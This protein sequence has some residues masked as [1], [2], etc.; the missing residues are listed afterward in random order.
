MQISTS[1]EL[2]ASLHF[3]PVA[4][5]FVEQSSRSL[6][7]AGQE[8]LALT[9]AA[10]ELFTRFSR[11]IQ[12]DQAVTIEC[13]AGAYYVRADFLFPVQ[14][15][16]LRAFNLTS[17][18]SLQD[19]AGLDE[20]GLF[21]ASRSVDQFQVLREPDRRVRLILIKERSYP[22]AG[23]PPALHPE[24][25]PSYT[26]RAPEAEELRLLAA[27][28][29][30]RY[31]AKDYP[32]FFRYPGK[33]ADMVSGGE[34]QAAV[35]LGPSGGMGG[36]LLWRWLT[37]QTAEF[38]GPYVFP[39]QPDSQM[40][41]DLVEACLNSLSRTP[42]VCLLGFYPLAS[43]P[44]AHFQA[45]GSFIDWDPHG[46]RQERAVYFRQLQEDAGSIAW[47]HPELAEYMKKEY[48]R[49]GL[50][51]EVQPV[52]RSGQNR[53]PHAVVATRLEVIQGRATL[54]PILSG[55]DNEALLKNHLQLF[56]RERLR[57]VF[58]ELDTGEGWHADFVPSLLQSGFSPRVIMPNAGRGDVIVFQV[59][60]GPE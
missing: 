40:A 60:S 1:L 25:P 47:C 27:S 12:P 5:A 21:L 34:S 19:E 55:L 13:R 4:T 33:V 3:L 14:A 50:L 28:I 10:E 26:V 20:M 51:R 15:L 11:F 46:G 35:A 54:R 37:P 45:L 48:R 52:I 30:H 41:A 29:H 49:L 36:G 56:A 31:E 38:F 6:G 22:E 17:T 53:E 39:Q 8:A 9:L 23:G 42:C 7:M 18:L 58:F 57:A 24:A 2:P 44:R 43:L 59:D 32:A 16:N